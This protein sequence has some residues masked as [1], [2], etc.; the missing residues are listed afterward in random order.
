M[1][2]SLT[3]P[4][5]KMSLCAVADEPSIT[6]GASQ[7][8]LEGPSAEAAPCRRTR[9]RPKSETC[10]GQGGAQQGAPLE[11]LA[12]SH[13]GRRGRRCVLAHRS[14]S[15]SFSLATDLDSEMLVHQAVRRFDVSVN[16]LRDVLVEV[17]NG[18]AGEGG[19]ERGAQPCTAHKCDTCCRPCRAVLKG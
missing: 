1:F 3:T 7:S 5:L 13:A 8:G 15:T 11:A 4:K 9:E 14:S 19:A 10:R 17:C 2:P 16:D 6:S 18:E 12:G